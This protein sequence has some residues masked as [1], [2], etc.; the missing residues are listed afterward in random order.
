MEP[1]EATAKR[2]FTVRP[3]LPAALSELR[4]LAKNLRWSYDRDI[5]DLFER[6]DPAGWASGV[7]DPAR[8]LAQAD[9]EHLDRLAGDEDYLLALSRA[10]ASLAGPAVE[11]RPGREDDHAEHDSPGEAFDHLVAYFSPEFGVTEAINQY[12]GGLGV[13]AGDHLKAAGDMGIP[14]VAVGLF[15]R[16]GYFHQELTVDGWQTERFDDVDPHTLPLSELDERIEV[17]LAGSPLVLRIWLARLGPSRMYLLDA[18]LR[19]NSEELRLVTD[20]LYGGDVEHRLR[21]EIV[22]GIGGVRALDALG[23]AVEV[24][25]TNEGHAG[26]MNLERIR[27]AMKREGLRFEEAF[28]AVRAGSVF[29]THTPVPAG[30]DLFPRSLIERYFHDW[31]R[32]CDIDIDRLMELG[33]LPG[34]QADRPFNMAIMG[35]RLSQFRNGVSRTHGATSRAMFTGLWPGIPDD[36]VP[37]GHVTNGVHPQSWLSPSMSDLLVSAMGPPRDWHLA[38]SSTTGSTTSRW[39][40]VGD[41]TDAELLGAAAA[42]RAHL[43]EVVR[44]RLV[45]GGLSTGRSPSELSWTESALDPD[46]L[47]IC[48]ARRMAAHK[49]AALLL[50]QPDRLRRLIADHDVQ[51]VFAG[52]AHPNDDNGK[53]AIRR[54]VAFASEP[55]VRGRFA[56]VADY[57]MALARALVQGADVWLNTPLHPLEAS[58]TSGMKAA[59]NGALNLSVLDGWWAQA[60]DGGTGPHDVPNGWAIAAPRG[61][62]GDSDPAQRAILDCEA[63]YE[64]LE[65]QVVP[66]WASSGTSLGDEERGP[67]WERVRR[68]LM[69]LGPLVDAH[70]MVDQYAREVYRPA[71][72]TSM[73][74]RDDDH[75]GARRL[76]A[77][78]KRV[79]DAWHGVR[80]ESV[81]TDES[82]GDLGSTRVVTA[83]VRLGELEPRDVRVQLLVG[84]LGPGGTLVSPEIT[85]M[86][87]EATTPALETDR[88]SRLTYRGE[89][90][91]SVPGRMGLTLRVLPDD[92]LLFD[93]VDLALV[94]WAS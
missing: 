21:Q 18:D 20:R 49:R 42:D 35:M 89:A 75:A 22:L 69:T 82:T 29:T 78:R 77:F 45:E 7:R 55:E 71:A 40:A 28:E 33:H 32:D 74:L 11:D 25:H 86:L 43:V 85:T 41:I 72:R 6:V 27:T 38:G 23:E 13:L 90:R 39:D 70:R 59:L 10:V 64:L 34:E 46:V 88:Q 83:A 57:D 76:A 5:Q 73:A 9:A 31:A 87:P 37:I 51:F 3:H 47:T 36:E 2:S 53:E 17:D 68:S 15:Y 16:H 62:N 79:T 93:P 50:E 58:G 63:L 30:I 66:L 14:L 84:H 61:T 80:V 54:L 81:D 26:F 65:N 94:T 92:P 44:R 8:L 24:F 4:T 19:E 52:K 67:W 60:F 1:V 12:S 56:F 48:F 91:L